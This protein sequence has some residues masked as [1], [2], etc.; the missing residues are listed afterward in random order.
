[1]AGTRLLEGR[2]AI[3]TGAAVGLGRA[4]AH[5]LAGKGAAVLIADIQKQ[6]VLKTAFRS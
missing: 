3:V 4:F 6:T 1:M 5:A 2:T